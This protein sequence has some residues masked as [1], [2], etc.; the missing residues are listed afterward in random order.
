[1]SEVVSL[2]V[3][4]DLEESFF[5]RGVRAVPLRRDSRR[6]PPENHVPFDSSPGFNA[7]RPALVSIII[8]LW[9][10]SHPEAG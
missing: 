5:T 9:N 1:M 10:Q 7:T 4:D 2:K 3:S 6:V 8:P